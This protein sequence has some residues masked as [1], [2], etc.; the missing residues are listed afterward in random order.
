MARKTLSEDEER[1]L[2]QLRL[3][4]LRTKRRELSDRTISEAVRL[5]TSVTR[6]QPHLSDQIGPVCST[7]DLSNLLGV[8]RQAINKAVQEGRLLAVRTGRGDWRYPTWQIE[9]AGGLVANLSAPLQRLHQRVPSM[10][11][12]IWFLTENHL[13]EGITPAAWLQ[14]HRALP[15][16]LAAA[17][18]FAAREAKPSSSPSSSSGSPA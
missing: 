11:A 6:P 14:Q 9:G 7:A 12:A 2:E 4:L 15:P 5:V 17:E 13:L 1:L 18:R 10:V 8:S 16:L 3:S